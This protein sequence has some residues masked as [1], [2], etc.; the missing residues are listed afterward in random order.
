MP[1][2]YDRP[3]ARLIA[4]ETMGGPTGYHSHTNK[5]ALLVFFSQQ[6]VEEILDAQRGANP[7]EYFNIK[8]PKGDPLYDPEAAGGKVIP[9]LRTRY[10]VDTGNSPGVPRIQLNEIT[11]WIDGGLTYGFAKAWSDALRAFDS[12]RPG[13][14]RCLQNDDGTENCEFPSQNMIWLPFVN[15]PTPK[16]HDLKPVSRFWMIG[17]PRGNENPALLSMGI[18]WFR[19]H[20]FHADRIAGKHPDWSDE[21]VYSVARQYVIA[22]HQHVIMYNWLPRFLGLPDFNMTP[23][24]GY[25]SSTFPGVAKEFQSA[26]MRFG[27]TMIVPGMYR[28]DPR[29]CA[30]PN[31]TDQSGSVTGGYRAVR[32][33][34]SYFNP[35]EPHIEAGSASHVIFGLASQ[36]AER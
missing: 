9:L 31:T 8:N 26:A 4:R 10:S 25:D 11:P 6:V 2:G 24:T 22:V 28:R 29:A 14:L 36:G 19:F 16:E 21:R 3:N 34:N 7:P 18:M 23:Y 5:S 15:P 32:T 30:F 1:S 13:R 12:K 33:C 27:H 17:N 20:N 35:Q